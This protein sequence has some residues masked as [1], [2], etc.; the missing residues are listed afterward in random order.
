MKPKIP[1]QEYGKRLLAL[2]RE[3]KKQD[4][5]AFVVSSLE[6]IYYLTG[7]G[8]EPLERPFFLVVRAHGRPKL[9]VPK[10]D[11]QHMLKA[12]GIDREDILT[13]REY[14]SPD[15]TGWPAKLMLLLGEGTRIGLEPTLR[16]EIAD[17]LACLSP[18]T[19]PLVERLRMV[20]S[21]AEIAMIRQAAHYADYGVERLLSSAYYGAT[22]A[23]G[24]A[25]TSTVSVK[26]IR[27]V[28]GWDAL[29]TK[30]LMASWAAPHSA[31]PH[32]V[33]A[34]GHRLQDGPHVALVLTRVNGYAAESERTFF[35]S[36]PTQQAVDA[37]AAMMEARELAFSMIKPGARCG[38]IDEAV[39]QFLER[40]GYGGAD[41]RLH[42]IGH[43]IGLGNHEAPW[44]AEGS[45]DR[46][47]E[48]M[49]I[50]IEPG[51][52]LQGLGGLRHSDTVLVTGDGCEQLTSAPADLDSLVVEK[53]K[54][55][56]RLK[57]TLIRRKLKLSA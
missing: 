6:S 50:S 33:P 41:K 14:P 35:T 55:L 56:T 34:L 4:L 25:E 57:G 10:L 30:V 48:N 17:E 42:R 31:M 3:I 52:Y 15:G 28:D 24:F 21:E 44:L 2:Q 16:R 1:P 7:A 8:F 39:S 27:E 49:V 12:Q 54:P 9:L 53:W 40:E 37:F 32:S 46:L 26:I 20:K 43:G 45:D 38:E 51:I 11:E 36:T 18:L 22:V 19:C 5:E 23:E 29:N 13:Y 47:E